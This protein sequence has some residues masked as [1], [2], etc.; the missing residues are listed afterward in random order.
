VISYQC[1]VVSYQ[2]SVVSYQLSVVTVVSVQLSVWNWCAW[3]YR[4]SL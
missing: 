2:L 1:S 4:V 3:L